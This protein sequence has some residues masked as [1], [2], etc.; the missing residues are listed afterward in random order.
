LSNATLKSIL[1]H[2]ASLGLELGFSEVS[3]LLDE[4]QKKLITD[5]NLAMPNVRKSLPKLRVNGSSR[6]NVVRGVHLTIKSG[7]P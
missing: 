4:N 2:L 6:S 7:N 1:R 3:S 5:H